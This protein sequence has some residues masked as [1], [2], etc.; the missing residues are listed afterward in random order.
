MGVLVLE[1]PQAQIFQFFSL[2]FLKSSSPAVISNEMLPLEDWNHK[3]TPAK[4]AF[5]QDMVFAG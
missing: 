4:T 5:L 2:S 1:F 3:P